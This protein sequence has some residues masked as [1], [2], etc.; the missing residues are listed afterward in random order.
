MEV[1]AV[2]VV[3]E[4]KVDAGRVGSLSMFSSLVAGNPIPA[5]DQPQPC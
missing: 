5:F 3:T 2:G 1:L 4:E